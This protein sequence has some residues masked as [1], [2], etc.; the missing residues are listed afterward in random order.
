MHPD[1]VAGIF[2]MLYARHRRPLGLEAAG[3]RRD[4]DH[5]GD[6]FGAGIGFHFPFAAGQF[7]QPRHHLA[8]MK[9]RV[10]GLD[11][12]HQLVH[13][14]LA[15]DDRDAG[16]VVDRFFGIK[17]GALAAGAVEDIHQMAFQIEQPQLEHGEQ[18]NGARA[19]DGDIGFNGGASGDRRVQR[20]FHT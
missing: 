18:A 3:A 12:R 2:V 9:L 7:F 10:E 11:L 15:G 19:D 17:L 6:E 5:R 16:N 8:K 20:V 4:H 14:L 1:A 13:Q